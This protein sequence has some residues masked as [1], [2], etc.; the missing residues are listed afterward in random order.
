M[1]AELEQVP[2]VSS[3]KSRYFCPDVTR[4]EGPGLIADLISWPS[5][6]QLT[7]VQSSK[8]GRYITRQRLNHLAHSQLS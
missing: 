2:L 5:T 6:L 8:L 4:L 7:I 3:V 1:E